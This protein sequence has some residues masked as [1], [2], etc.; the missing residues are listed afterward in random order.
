M[1]PVAANDIVLSVNPHH[2]VS[3]VEKMAVFNQV[4]PGGVVG[5]VVAVIEKP[6][7]K[8]FVGNGQ[9]NTE[10]TLEAG[11]DTVRQL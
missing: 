7:K 4:V 2:M 8:H 10:F 5:V 11:Q 1:K 9:P 6:T 3:A